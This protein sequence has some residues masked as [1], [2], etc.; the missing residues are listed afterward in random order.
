M[1]AVAIAAS[2]AGLAWRLRSDPGALSASL[3]QLVHAYYLVVGDAI[4]LA[5][6]ARLLE[7][8]ALVA[9]T[10]T[11]FRREP[12]LSV[13]LPAALIASASIAALSSVLLWRGI[14][15][16]LALQLYDRIGYRVSAHIA[17]V[18]A[19]GSYFAMM[20]CLALGMAA[21]AR[22]RSRALWI[23]GV[24]AT[25]TGLWFSE[26]RSAFAALAVVVSLAVAWA[27]TTR[28]P[29]RARAGALLALLCVVLTLG[30]ARVRL[31][32]R[33]PTYKGAGF[34]SQF[35]ASSLRMIAARPVFGVGVGQYYPT[36]ALFLSPQLAWTYGMENAHNFF[37]QVGAELGV[38]GLALLI[39][40]LGIAFAQSASAIAIAPRDW[41]LLG[42]AGAVA[43]L[44]GTCLTG[45]PLLVDE[46]MVPFWILFGL[47]TGLAGST[48]LNAVGW[49]GSRERD[50]AVRR[51]GWMITATAV[52]GVLVWTVVGA[53]QRPLGPLASEAVDGFDGWE[54]APDGARFRW[55]GQYASVFVPD[56]VST[57]QIP[58]RVPAVI[59][60]VTPGAVEISKGGVTI[61]RTPVSDAWTLI[62]VPVDRSTAS[63]HFMRINLRSDN[64]WRPAL[65]VPGSAQLR[66]VGVQVGELRLV[67]N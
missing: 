3:D 41:R 28:W 50:H 67:R 44:C 52:A 9:A 26:S 46:V 39:V 7:G 56:D 29:A 4:G 63:A 48:L 32:D 14:G 36:S 22:G 61:S 24:I 25:A 11:L 5:D 2:I 10:L 64:T 45:H 47:T 35:N 49:D 16:A 38:V 55:T 43:T 31:L 6:G 59:R 30:Y 15:S 1:L 40:W 12:R 23:A 21:R 19:S 57:V 51:K 66:P 65:Y 54:T 62:S 33:D 42:V 37:L 60:N 34:R 8:L 58:V 13:T 17:D 27:A 53:A 20:L 18:N